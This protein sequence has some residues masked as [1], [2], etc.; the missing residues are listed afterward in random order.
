MIAYTHICRYM[1]VTSTL[2]NTWSWLLDSEG[3]LNT[4]C[5]PVNISAV[6]GEYGAAGCSLLQAVVLFSPSTMCPLDKGNS[7][8]LACSFFLF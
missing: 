7:T 4:V 2:G 8:Y 3:E 6:R 1:S 5:M